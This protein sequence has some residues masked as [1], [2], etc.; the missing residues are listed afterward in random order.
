[1]ENLLVDEETKEIL[2]D[3]IKNTD[4]FL[5]I[6]GAAGSGKTTSIAWALNYCNQNNITTN[7]VSYTGKA[8]SMIRDKT[9][10]DYGQTIHLFLYQYDYD[11]EEDEF[12][13]GESERKRILNETPVD[14][15]F[16]DESSMISKRVQG[17]AVND[18]NTYLLDELIN[19][20]CKNNS[21][22][23]VFVGD[24][25]QLA[26]VE[27]EDHHDS[28]EDVNKITDES[29]EFISEDSIFTDALNENVLKEH[30]NLRGS[31]YTPIENYRQEKESVINNIQFDLAK[32]I[33]I[34]EEIFESPSDWVKENFPD[35]IF[36][37]KD[38]AYAWLKEKRDDVGW[39][40]TRV[41]S[42]FN[43]SVDELNSD[44]RSTVEEMTGEID[45]S[46]FKSTHPLMNLRNKH[47]VEIYNGD[48]FFIEETIEENCYITNESFNCEKTRP[49]HMKCSQDRIE[50][51][52]LNKVKVS[53]K[54][55]SGS[56]KEV[57]MINELIKLE[58][59]RRDLDDRYETNLW[60]DFA[61]RNPELEE[62]K[63]FQWYQMLREDEVKNALIVV[64]AFASTVH[65]AQG[66]EFKYVLVDLDNELFNLKW[67]YTA[68]TRAVDEVR[69]L[70]TK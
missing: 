9:N 30:Y 55:D 4:D 40:N 54:R 35:L 20:Q 38:D 16:V 39:L 48:T 18:E 34:K 33:T 24:H 1:M 52:K 46:K 14:I 2:I 43:S 11:N 37:N 19:L 15:L 53:L 69:F 5:I 51:F 44:I 45:E 49:V 50:S 7:A 12:Q 10:G 26:P 29:E 27:K 36:T 60:L 70:Y 6:D 56:S 17:F 66:D 25:R 65:K 63:D 8:A 61:H 31:T 32:K 47:H 13:E 42:G 3:F 28:E 62:E 58:I 23:I 59:A 41:V 22:K 67:L 68:I 57:L 64:H 21:K